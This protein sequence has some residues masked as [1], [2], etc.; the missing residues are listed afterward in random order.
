MSISRSR[1]PGRDL[2]RSCWFGVDCLCSAQTIHRVHR[3][4]MGAR[5]SGQELRGQGGELMMSH[6]GVFEHAFQVS[7]E[8]IDRLGH[9]NNVVN[10]RYAQDAAVA[11]WYAVVDQDH[12]DNMVWVVRRHEIDYLNRL[13]RT[14]SW[15]HE[16][17]WAPPAGQPSSGSSRSADPATARCWPASAASGWPSMRRRY[18]PGESPSNSARFLRA[19]NAGGRTPTARDERQRS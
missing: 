16:P 15:W 3:T 1:S 14:M 13:W 18:A 12:R 11:H 6:P 4:R 5:Q 17:G 9:V 7:R 10:L 8:D 2:V 19:A